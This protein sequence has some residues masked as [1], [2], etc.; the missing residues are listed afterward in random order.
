MIHLYSHN[1]LNNSLT[2]R[3]SA[4]NE[5]LHGQ[6]RPGVLVKTCNRLEF[7]EGDGEVPG[8]IAR[9]LFRVVSGLD[10]GLIGETAIQGQIKAAYLEACVTYTLSKGIHQLFQTALSV[11]KR[12]R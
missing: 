2:Q 7:Y 3:E 12:V 11:G 8:P 4:M 1:Q 9:H 5:I 6:N 10:S